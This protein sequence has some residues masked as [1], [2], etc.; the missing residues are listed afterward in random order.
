MDTLVHLLGAEFL[1]SAVRLAAPLLL[2]AL[3]GLLC[4]RSGV[5]NIALE[6]MMLVG[7][8][9]GVFGAW[10]SGSAVVG[11]VCAVAAGAA[12]AALH[13]LLAVVLKADQIVSGAAIN[14]GA[15][16]LTSFL[17]RVIFGLA[18]QKR[19]V[20]HL[21]PIAVP[22]LAE[23]PLLG[24][25]LF[26]HIALVYLA[27]ALVP[28]LA[29]MLYRT[30]WGLAVQAVG[31]HPRAADAAGIRVDRTRAACVLVGGS[32]AGLGGAFLSLGQ[33]HF[34]VDDMVGGR[35]FIALAALVFGRWDPAG[36]ALACLV[37]GAAD[38]MQFRMQAFGTGI[39]HQIFLMLPYA[40]TLGVLIVF[41]G[42]SR[43]PA[44]LGIPYR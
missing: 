8:L 37:F 17:L 23:L 16:G 41:A 7:A 44:A 25:V 1:A 13:A 15:L 43:A 24:P 5:V 36:T 14:I 26:R 32:L 33:L 21:E 22:W 39:P 4:E 28:V 42:R 31:E 6:G 10:A 27:F 18:D 11:L 3:G 40:A 2:A 9:A 34:F 35:G 12:T 19:E 30:R 20:P 38:A 29:W